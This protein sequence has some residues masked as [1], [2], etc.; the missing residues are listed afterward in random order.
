MYQELKAPVNMSI[1][2]QTGIGFS[3]H[4]L[5]YFFAISVCKRYFIMFPVQ[6][7]IIMFGLD[8]CIFGVCQKHKTFDEKID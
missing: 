3:L 7:S 6:D 1:K 4:L 8:F 5:K 2:A